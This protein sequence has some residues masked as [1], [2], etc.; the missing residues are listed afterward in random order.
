MKILPFISFAFCGLTG[1]AAV[2][3]CSYAF[4]VNY[5]PAPIQEQTASGLETE[6]K[7]EGVK[8]RKLSTTTDGDDVITTLSYEVSADTMLGFDGTIDE[9]VTARAYYQKSEES[10]DDVIKVAIDQEN[11]LIKINNL[12]HAPFGDVVVVEISSLADPEVKALINCNYRKR[13]TDITLGTLDYSIG[14][15][16]N[17]IDQIMKHS[18][19]YNV[20][21]Y[22]INTD[23]TGA[24]YQALFS[25]S[26]KQNTAALNINV[27]EGDETI[28]TG[29]WEDFNSDMSGFEL[30]QETLN[31]FIQRTQTN[32]KNI[33]TWTN[34]ANAF[35]NES[36][37]WNLGNDTWHDFIKFYCNGSF[38]ISF[39]LEGVTIKEPLTGSVTAGNTTNY[40]NIKYD[41]NNFGI[42]PDHITVEDDSVDF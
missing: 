14:D 38:K 34:L 23:F 10:T 11:K 1:V 24:A 4:G 22:T 26:L 16:V 21:P 7:E 39:R 25:A 2:A 3:G 6:I 36:E 31:E 18:N 5:G 37:V 20:T 27:L 30:V 41:F 40:I 29:S 32:F 33:D 19:D 28:G 42:A 8:I 35:L 15:E 17:L 9:R 13:L 12:K